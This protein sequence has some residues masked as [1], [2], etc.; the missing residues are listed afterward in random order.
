MCKSKCKL[1]EDLD[2]FGK[3]PE[4]YYKGKSKRSS[5]VGRFFTIFY[6]FLY[7]AFFIYK[8]IRMI[9]KIDITFYETTTFTGDVPS[10]N[11]NNENFYGGFALANPLTL[12]TFIDE[13]VYYPK[14]TF[15]KGKKIGNIWNWEFE[16][17]EVERC[18]LE[19]FGSKYRELFKDKLLNDL[20]CFK[21]MNFTIEGHTTYDVYSYFHIGFFP[22][23]NSTSNN[24]H[25]KSYE[26]INKILKRTMV[27]VKI[28]D[29]ELT[30]ENY[31]YPTQVKARE[32]SSAVMTDLYQNINA[33]FHI[34][35]IETD[36]D[37]L[38]FEAL[39]RI[40]SQKFFKYDVT[41][42]MT[43][44]N[45]NDILKTGDGI[46][47]ITIQ[48][49]EQMIT[50]KRT[51][52]KLIEVLGDVGGLMEFVFSLFNII[53]NFLTDT[54]YEI[55]LVNNLFSFDIQKKIVIIKDKKENNIFSSNEAINI[56]SQ[57]KPI[58]KQSSPQNSIYINDESKTITKKEEELKNDYINKAYLITKKPKKI[59]KKSKIKGKK[60][61]STIGK[62]SFSS[63][64]GKSSDERNKDLLKDDNNNNNINYYKS[65]LNSNYMI[66][67]NEKKITFN[68]EKDKVTIIDKIRLNKYYIYLCFFYARKKKNIQNSLLDEGMK[69]ISDRLDIMNLFKKLYRDEKF[70]E[71]FNIEDDIIEMSNE[72]KR[73]LKD[74]LKSD[75]TI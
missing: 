14:A 58:L 37:I 65:S 22:C 44:S 67:K 46:C 23:V 17:I 12:N 42:I 13:T 28:Q 47:D 9:K 72:C 27:T 1:L 71:K 21:E 75:C 59:K 68:K 45:E 49:T 63:S 20:Y 61:S 35:D 73:N 69:I 30:P 50:I 52:T 24:N 62:A 39:S 74:L 41:F 66:S 33:Y 34:I 54:L 25:C 57:I 19:K 11:L 4:L 40:N 48:L 8:V 31:N 53:S 56:S 26:E 55:S 70:I 6:T 18:Q 15:I 36:N 10:L 38:G 2:L 7:T 16:E 60:S 29:V 3:E 64:Y 5:R 51:Y 43:S 32:L